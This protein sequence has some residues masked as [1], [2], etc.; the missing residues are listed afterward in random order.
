MNSIDVRIAIGE[1]AG[2]GRATQSDSVKSPI[3]DTFTQAASHIQSNPDQTDVSFSTYGSR[4]EHLAVV[5]RN[6][7]T[8]EVIREV[9]SE[10]MQ[11]LHVHLEVMV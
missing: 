6:K 2:V 1:M 10:E 4:N 3:K 5:I 8:G 9:P 7:E 11:K